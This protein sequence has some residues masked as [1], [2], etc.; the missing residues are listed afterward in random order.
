MQ[1]LKLNTE[2]ISQLEQKNNIYTYLLFR[3]IDTVGA[4][5]ATGLTLLN[6]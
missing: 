1:N 2:L 6:K 5:I 4:V 3:I